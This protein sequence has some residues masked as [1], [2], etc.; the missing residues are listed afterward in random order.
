EPVR[1]FAAEILE[2]RA[3]VGARA[4]AEVSPSCFEQP[5][6]EPLDDVEIYSRG[7]ERAAGAI[8]RLHQLVLDQPG[9]ADEDSLSRKGREGL[10]GRIAIASWAQRQCLPPALPGLVKT[11]DPL[12]G[13]WTDVANSVWRGQRRDMEQEAGCAVLRRERRQAHAR[14]LTA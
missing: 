2:S 8:A 7:R 1:L 5:I 6:L 13:S 11:V 3:Q 9:R 4:A 10:I 12:D 14:P